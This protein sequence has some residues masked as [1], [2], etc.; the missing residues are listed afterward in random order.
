MCQGNCD[1]GMSVGE[2]LR[3]LSDTNPSRKVL[4]ES[5][6]CNAVADTTFSVD[7]VVVQTNGFVILASVEHQMEEKRDEPADPEV[8]AEG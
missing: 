4:F 5:R 7:E 6:P 2:L 3:I 8:A 1:E